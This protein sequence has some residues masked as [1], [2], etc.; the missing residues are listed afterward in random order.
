MNMQ[1]AIHPFIS[2][3]YAINEYASAITIVNSSGTQILY[4]TENWDISYDIPQLL[5]T[6]NSQ[7]SSVSVQGI[8]YMALQNTPERL[9][10]TNIK[11]QGHIVAARN[12]NVVGVA[13]FMPDA[14]IGSSYTDLA[15]A[16]MGINKQVG[17]QV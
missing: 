16:V 10:C 6:W 3:L 11:G 12:G 4:Q 9:V 13:Y 17:Y 14:D 1:N 2:E 8:N 5:V 15:R 7:G